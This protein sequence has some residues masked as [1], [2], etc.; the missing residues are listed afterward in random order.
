M[1]FDKAEEYLQTQI[2]L[3]GGYNRISAKMILDDVQREHGQA[4]SDRSIDLK[5]AL[6]SSPV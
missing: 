6:D 3:A 4:A 5:H 2:S 1:T